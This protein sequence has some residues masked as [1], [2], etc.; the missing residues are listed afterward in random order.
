MTNMGKRMRGLSRGLAAMLLAVMAAAACAHRQPVPPLELYREGL[1]LE[2]QQKTWDAILVYREALRDDPK[3]NEIRLHLADLLM[4][5]GDYGSAERNY[6]IIL[7]SDPG[8]TAA[9]NNLSWVYTITGHHLEWAA[10][11]MKPIAEQPSPHR[12]VYLDTLGT[13]YLKQKKYPE[14]AACFQEA[15]DLCR[16]GVVMSTSDECDRIND[17]LRSA[18]ARQ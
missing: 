16:K 10:A 12:H 5:T 3:D 11:A 15:S 9:I 14:A 13:V 7:D 1:A 8:D 17:H 18:K 4:A 6:R 2:R